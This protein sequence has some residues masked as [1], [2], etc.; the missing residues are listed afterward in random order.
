[1]LGEW[2]GGLGGVS[3]LCGASVFARR[4][5]GVEDFDGVVGFFGV[6]ASDEAADVERLCHG[7]AGADDHVE[8]EAGG[9]EEHHGAKDDGDGDHHDFLLLILRGGWGESLLDDEEGDAE[10]GKDEVGVAC[11]EV[12]NPEREWG[13]VEAAGDENATIEGEEDGHLEQ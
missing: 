5:F 12:G 9:E 8:A 1:M 4:V 2:S 3:A 13:V 10:D 11:G 6:F 7:E